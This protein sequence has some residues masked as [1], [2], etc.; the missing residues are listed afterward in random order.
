MKENTKKIPRLAAW[1]IERILPGYDRMSL[2][3]DF[4]EMYFEKLKEKGVFKAK[5]WLWSQIFRSTPK[6]LKKSFYWSA[7]MFKNYLKVAFRNLIRQK[8]YSVIN[9]AGLAIGMSVCFLILLWVQDELNFDNFHKNKDNIYRMVIKDRNGS[10]DWGAVSSLPL[11]PTL[12]EELPEVKYS[13]TITFPGRLMFSYEE[14]SFYVSDGIFADPDFFRM[15]SFEFIYGDPEKAFEGPRSLVI[16]RETSEKFFGNENPVGKTLQVN[17]RA[18]YTIT[19]VLENIPLNSHLRFNFI[20]PFALLEQFG[21]DRSRW[22]DVSYF[23]YIQLDGDHNIA[24]LESKID[25]IVMTHNPDDNNQC[26][27]Q[28]LKDIHLSNKYSYEI[29]VTGD[30]KYVYIFSTAALFILIIACINFINLSTARSGKRAKE[31][32]LRKVVGA[33]R[34]EI[35][36]QFFGESVLYTL[37][38]FGVTLIFIKISLTGFNSLTG[39]SFDPGILNA[40]G[41]VL[42]LFGIAI[43][44][45]IISGS[46]PAL[47]LSSYKPISVFKGEIVHDRKGGSLFRKIMV[48]TQFS[49]SIILI[50]GT[51]IIY[52]QIDFIRN[53]DLGIEKDQLV[54]FSLQGDMRSRPAAAKERLTQNSNILNATVIDNLPVALGS[55]TDGTDW[56]GKS[57]D[58]SFQVQAR[59]VDHDMLNTFGLEMIEGR[60]FSKDFPSDSISSFVLNESAVRGMKMDSPVGKRF[61]AFGVE[62]RIIGVVNDFHFTSLHKKIPPLFMLLGRRASYMCLRIKP[63]NIPETIDQIESV[64][65]DF[66]GGF[67]FE[68]GFL[69]ERIDTMYRSEERIGN[70]FRYFTFLAIFISCLGLFGLTSYMAES[71][72]KEI[73]VR[74]VLGASVRNISMSLSKEFFYWIIAANIVAWP[75]SYVIMNT[76]LQGFAYRIEIGWEV[77]IFAGVLALV[78]TIAT[79]AFQIIKAAV[80]NPVRSLRYE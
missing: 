72:T 56:E 48:I 23:T 3:G 39:K 32:G 27:L 69:D 45:G 64:W 75:L 54:Y 1:L 6:F 77:F 60:F 5:I 62:G 40:S 73:G 50:V 59:F 76:W 2:H 13:T 9:I 51:L 47:L 38:A 7:V 29:A 26:F 22:D 12:K 30:V 20:R 34:N 43:I 4:D 28:K 70:I 55:G 58:K 37:I 16:T 68:Y 74:K 61:S 15:F 25:K 31:V 35:I 14:K 24:E 11:G 66:A 80:A 63:D 65:K 8:Y 19:G 18:S 41:L 42:K 53:K 52:E 10:G 17:T 46:Y 44:T 57:D 21:V 79:T 71:R 67:P 78:I 36:K 33:G 49:L